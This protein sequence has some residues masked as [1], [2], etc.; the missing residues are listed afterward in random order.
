MQQ[1]ERYELS[2]RGPVRIVIKCGCPYY[3]GT[4]LARL[5]GYKKPYDAVKHFVP[6]VTKI[7]IPC[8]QSP[9]HSRTLCFLSEFQTY[10]FVQRQLQL[11]KLKSDEWTLDVFIKSLRTGRMPSILRPRE[12]PLEPILKPVRNT[13]RDGHYDGHELD[14]QTTLTLIKMYKSFVQD[15]RTFINE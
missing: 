13:D 12:V 2:I 6:K 10:E 8:K 11:K 5:F 15:L 4:D 1:V 3:C 7:L 14:V 9:S